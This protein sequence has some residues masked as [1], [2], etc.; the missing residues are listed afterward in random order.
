MHTGDMTTDHNIN[1]IV[2]IDMYAAAQIAV[3]FAD[4]DDL[5]VRLAEQN[6]PAKLA[7]LRKRLFAANAK[8]LAAEAEWLANA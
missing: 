5:A 3:D 1:V 2:P 6:R 4:P 7:Q 8:C